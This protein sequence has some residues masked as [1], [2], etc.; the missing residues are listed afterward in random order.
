MTDLN[1]LIHPALGWTLTTANA[2]NDSGQIVGYGNNG[3]TT[4]AY[5]LTP[6]DEMTPIPV[7][8]ALPML[9]A[10][11]AALWWVRRRAA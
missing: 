8:P 1:T 6:V 9:A 2:I 4:R 5:L 7:P 10:G 3:S 11:L